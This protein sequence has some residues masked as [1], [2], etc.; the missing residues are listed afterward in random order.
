MLGVPPDADLIDVRAAYLRLVRVHHPDVA[1]GRSEATAETARL[2]EAWSV[3][4]RGT[5]TD[6]APSGPEAPADPRAARHRPGPVA[7]GRDVDADVAGSATPDFLALLDAASALGEVTWAD[8]HAQMVQVV[9]RPDPSGPTC[10][11]V[12][13]LL[14]VEDG[15]A[16]RTALESLE[17]QPAPPLEPLAE[18]LAALVARSARRLGHDG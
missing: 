2:T 11:L 15:F 1:P 14:Q 7:D 16:L 8:R 18:Q 17:A 13:G 3:L 9:L 6:D 4:R 5:T 12:A 10:Q